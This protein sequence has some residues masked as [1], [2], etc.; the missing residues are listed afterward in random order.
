MEV[1]CVVSALEDGEWLWLDGCTWKVS[2][3]H[4]V[5]SS[6]LLIHWQPLSQGGCSIQVLSLL[7]GLL[8]GEIPSFSSS[9]PPPPDA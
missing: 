7:D 6:A 3:G 8:K 1:S 9:N 5:A 4:L 2:A